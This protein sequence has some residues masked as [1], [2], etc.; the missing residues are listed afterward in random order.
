MKRTFTLSMAW[1]HSWAGLFFAWLLFGILFTGA[2]AVFHAEVT[3]WVTPEMRGQ[4]H[5]DRDKA[6]EVGRAYLEEHAPDA[7]L[8]RLTLPSEREPVV[9]V[10]WR[11]EKGNGTTRRLQPDTGETI[12]RETRGGGFF[13]D[14][15]YMINLSRKDIALG[16]VGLW[17]VG[18][19]GI[20]M[21]VA[22]ISGIVVHK[23]IFRDLFLFRPGASRHRSWLDAHN[24]LSVLPLPFHIII[25]YTGLVTLYWLYVPAGINS[26]YAGSEDAFRREAISQHYVSLLD[27]PPPGPP[28]P[29]MSLPAINRQAEAQF[30][31]GKTAY[32][33]M[34][35]PNRANAMVEAFRTRADRV[36]QQVEQIA[37]RGIDGRQIRIVEH[38]TATKIQSFVAAIHF[39]E[40]GGAVIRWAYFLVGLAA[41]AMVATGL[42][43][44]TAK[45]E[46]KR[47]APPWLRL[48]QAVN[49]ASVAGLCIACAVFFWA[50]RLTP[51]DLPARAGVPVKFFFLS[52]LACL[53][54]AAL[55]PPHCAWREQFA[56]AAFLCFAAPMLGG[57]G[58]LHLIS[59]DTTR[60]FFDL[61]FWIFGAVFAFLFFKVKGTPTRS[62]H[63]HELVA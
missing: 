50:E 35:D 19:A 3:Y 45:R 2:I 59:W 44:F 55:R 12:Q 58:W 42:V 1:L 11:D 39:V 30:G 41:A 22:C 54:H 52:W 24:V 15:H 18:M 57:Q 53:A 56:L 23:R 36:T 46:T 47:G 49:V 14:Y 20:V 29:M 40:W 13:I 27:A 61:T 48:V 6:I 9:K 33:T 16:P 62:V 28:A 5:D 38:S 7:R 26:L 43:V 31:A 4:V 37:Y 60:L 25:V 17:I 34:R 8:W 63:R 10:Y 21:L 51:A 32:L